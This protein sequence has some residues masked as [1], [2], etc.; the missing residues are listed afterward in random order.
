MCVH[1]PL[2]VCISDYG[3]WLQVAVCR[4]S[5]IA[6]LILSINEQRSTLLPRTPSINHNLSSAYAP[7]SLHPPFTP[8]RLL[9]NSLHP[10]ALHVL[11]PLSNQICLLYFSTSV[12]VS[13]FIHPI[14]SYTNSPLLPVHP[15]LPSLPSF[16]SPLT[17][18][19]LSLSG[20]PF[21]A[22]PSSSA[23]EYGQAYWEG[24]SLNSQ[25]LILP[26]RSSKPFHTSKQ[27]FIG[28]IY[29]CIDT[30]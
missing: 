19:S 11:P 27:W 8:S 5:Y 4:L 14:L 16:F 20:C 17:P 24:F 10:L 3:P 22:L 2:P 21:L 26:T 28:P 9:S 13:V 6:S 29:V 23:E 30:L 1:A 18:F 12:L 15:L 7:H 25:V